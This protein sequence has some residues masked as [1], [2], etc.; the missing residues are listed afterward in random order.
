MDPSPR[1]L[2]PRAVQLWR[3]A[4]MVRLGVFWLPVSL[5]LG[6][7]LGF[8]L[9]PTAGLV[10]AALVL[11]VAG[12]IAL[13]WPSLAYARFRYALRE[14]DL[15]VER[16]VLFRTWTSVPYNRIQ[17]VDTRQGPLERALG[18]S[19]VLVFTASGLGADSSIPGLDEQ[20]AAELRDLLSRRGG[21]DGV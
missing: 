12:L 18:L 3:L 9:A 14:H 4:G 8:A 1:A 7:A 21:D 13:V 10:A 20:T 5:G 2:D 6:G 17:H 16:G 15:L 19:R 11:G